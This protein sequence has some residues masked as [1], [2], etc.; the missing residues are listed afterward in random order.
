MPAY[1]AE[2]FIAESIE[3]II[4]QTYQNWELLVVNDGS[5]DLTEIIVKNFCDNDSRIKYYYQQN[6]KQGKARNVGIAHAKGKYLAFLDADDVWFSEKIELQLKQIEEKKV[7]LVFSEAY[8]FT[9]TIT[10]TSAKMN[11]GKGIFESETGIRSFLG[12]NKIPTSTVLV[13]KEIINK[14]NGFTESLEIAPAEDYHLWLRL[15]MSGCNFFGS[16]LVLAGYRRHASATTTGDN[17]AVSYVIEALEDLKRHYEVYNK[18]ISQYQ[19]QWFKRYHYSFVKWNKTNYRKLIKKNCLYM[20]RRIY[21][22]F[23]QTIYAIFGLNPT[24]KLISRL[25]NESFT[26]D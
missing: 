12:L 19:K 15:L 8:V 11:S 13:K 25:L 5:A 17:L 1:N 3:S 22:P 16:P 7:D 6:G 4:R 2:K 9:D 14:A 18:L 26:L 23:F 21:N 20:N 10:N 24:R